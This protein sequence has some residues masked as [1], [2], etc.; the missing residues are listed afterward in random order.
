VSQSEFN[1]G[2]IIHSAVNH[3]EEGREIHFTVSIR[4]RA[5]TSS[6]S[7]C[8]SCA[9]L[10]SAETRVVAF[11]HIWAFF[12][13]CNFEMVGNFAICICW[14]EFSFSLSSACRNGRQSISVVKR[15]VLVLLSAFLH[16]KVKYDVSMIKRHDSL[17]HLCFSVNSAVVTSIHTQI[18]FLYSGNGNI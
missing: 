12:D 18:S 13:F 3:P 1:V 10:V 16:L 8:H 17:S 2:I 14:N 15:L 5:L 4:G 9:I 6:S 7:V 11:P